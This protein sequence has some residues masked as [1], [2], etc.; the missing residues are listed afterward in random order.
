M[1]LNKVDMNKLVLGELYLW[2]AEPE[3]DN[4][5]LVRLD[6]T[7]DGLMEIDDEEFWPFEDNL[8]GSV[9]GPVKL[10]D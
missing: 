9:Y 3:K 4:F 2:A 10:I 5:K 6:E 1:S 7:G 8:I